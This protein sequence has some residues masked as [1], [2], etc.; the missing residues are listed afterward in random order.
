MKKILIIILFLISNKTYSQNNWEQNSLINAIDTTNYLVCFNSLY[1]TQTNGFNKKFIRAIKQS[2]YIS[3]YLKKSN[4]IKTYNYL[5]HNLNQEFSLYNMPDS[6][7]GMDKTG[8][9]IGL[10]H[11]QLFTYAFKDDLYNIVAFG[12][13]MFAGKEVDFS[14]SLFQFFDYGTLSFGLYK[15]FEDDNTVTKAIFDFNLHAFKDIQYLYIRNAS[16]YTANDGSYIDL[17][18]QGDY[19]AKSNK[20]LNIPGIS[21]NAGISLYNKS[22]NTHFLFQVEQ[23]GVAFLNNKSYHA[24]IDTIIHYEGI[25]IENIISN[26]E[27]NTGFL[28]NDS[29]SQLYNKHLDTSS[30]VLFLPETILFSTNHTFEHK[31]FSDINLGISYQFH[32]KQKRPEVFI[33]QSIKINSKFQF[34]LGSSIGGYTSLSPFLNVYYKIGKNNILFL[35]ITNPLSYAISDYS[36]NTTILFRFKRYW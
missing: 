20:K 13:K 32:T 28:S 9:H 1:A 5:F 24:T 33:S 12:N 35:H 27:Y 29:I 26:P 19:R 23:V 14:Q 21:F 18:L 17:K 16:I 15:V 34:A 8:Y 7:F 2:S 10:A 36:Y 6:L 4:P 25:Q 30:S 22:S 31:I 11:K 3:D